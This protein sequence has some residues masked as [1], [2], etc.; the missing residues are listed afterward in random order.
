MRIRATAAIWLCLLTSLA[1]GAGVVATVDRNVIAVNESFQLTFETDANTGQPDFSPLQQDFEILNQSQSQNL[2]I[3]NGQ[4]SRQFLWDLTL[5]ATQAGDFQIPVISFGTEKSQPID[6]SVKN[7]G[8]M[9]D[10]DKTIDLDVEVDVEQPYVQQQVIFTV[11]LSRSV[12]IASASLSELQVEGVDAI[13]ERLGDDKEYQVMRNGRRWRV[14]ERTYVVFPQQSGH[15]IIRPLR[16]QGNLLTRSNLGFD[17]FNQSTSRPVVLKSES[18]TLRVREPPA[19]SAAHWLPAK[20]LTLAESWPV[21]DEVKVGDPITREITIQ[22]NGLTAAQLPEL[23]LVLPDSLRIYPE[24]PRLEDAGGADGVIGTRIETAAIIPTQPGTIALPE[25]QLAWWNI[26]KQQPE[27]AIIP[28]R[29]IEVGAGLVQAQPITTLSPVESPPTQSVAAST[30][31]DN[32]SGRPMLGDWWPWVSLG[33]GVA[34]LITIIMWLV[35]RQSKKHKP[36]VVEASPTRVDPKHALAELK[37]AIHSNNAA[38]SRDALIKWG[39]ALWPQT[40]PTN[41]GQLATL[42]GGP[43]S[44]RV[45]DLEQALYARNTDWDGKRLWQELLAFKLTSTDKPGQDKLALEPL[46]RG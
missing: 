42:C 36:E 10:D 40:P 11:R 25:V 8:T 2:S 12:D 20:N 38:K 37:Q 9:Q 23:D 14:V 46:Y 30:D 28:A 17:I 44:H 19:S 15:M 34:W 18:V 32:Q 24:Q 33:L 35:E 27:L 26:D 43:L 13:V 41:L 29:T 21:Q 7:Q 39:R 16:F 6:I 45:R 1:F 22:A 31:V 4:T 3:V 5:M